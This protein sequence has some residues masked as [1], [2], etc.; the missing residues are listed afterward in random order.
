MQ[1][2]TQ[3]KHHVVGDVDGSIDTANIGPAQALDH[4]QWGR[5]RQVDVT[6]N[7]PQVTW[8][9]SRGQHLDR[10]NVIMGRSNG[11]HSRAGNGRVIQGA[12]FTGQ[13]SQGQAVAT[14]RGQVD[15]DAG[16]VQIQVLTDVL[17]NRCIGSQLQ[18]TVVFFTDLQLGSRAQHAVGL[19]ATQLGFLDLEVARQFGTDHGKR[20][21]QTWANVGCATH[22]LEGLATVAD[23][24]D[25]QLVGIR[26]LFG[27]QHLAYNDTTELA[28]CRGDAVDLKASH[29]Q[30]SNQLVTGYLR[31]DPT[32]Q[33]LF[34]E[35]HSALLKDSLRVRDLAKL[36]KEPQI[37]VEEQTQ[38]V[39]AV[40]EHGQA[41]GTHAEGEALVLFRV[42]ARHAQDV[43]GPCRSP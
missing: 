41:L 8:A 38:I 5:T 23:L 40:T 19:N 39:D 43:R 9:G 2:L 14:V 35:F 26:V 28:G 24:A 32:A 10:A 30:T 22:D 1:R 36:R 37:V 6:D 29:G 12:D 4:P 25:T 7:T 21:F 42:D 16:V 33:P 34:T 13:A 17:A 3:F 11:R 27:A 31:V 18:Q 20:D 15:L